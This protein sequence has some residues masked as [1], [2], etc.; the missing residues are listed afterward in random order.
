SILWSFL[1]RSRSRLAQLLDALLSGHS[2]AWAL[3]GPRI[4]TRSLAPNRQTLAVPKAPIAADIAE[5]RDVLL[6][7]A[8]EL[9]LDHVLVVQQR[10]QL[11]QVV[12]CQVAGSLVGIDPGPNAKL[13][14]EE[15]TNAVNVA[16]RNYRALVVGNID[17]QNTRHPFRSPS[18]DTL[19]IV[20]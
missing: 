9:A 16:Q 4:G 10:G 17:T 13:F 1:V 2:L 19:A 12:L 5:P 6:N 7:L 3:P 14:G 8:T 15:G 18:I 20:S 11:G